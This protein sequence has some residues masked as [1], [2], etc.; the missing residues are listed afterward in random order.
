MTT[1]LLAGAAKTNITPPIGTHMGGFGARVDG[2]KG[3]HDT[4]WAKALVLRNDDTAVALVACD[5]LGLTADVIRP[6]R[7]AI[8]AQLGV[9]VEHVMV[10]CSHTH[11]GPDSLCLN[12]DVP[13]PDYFALVTKQIASA[14]ELAA[15]QLR[16]AR[17][18]WGRG[19]ADGISINR[20]TFE[21]GPLDTEVGVL[22]VEDEDQR[23]LALVVNFACHPVTLG[24]N[25]LLFCADYPGYAMNLLEQADPGCVALFT[26]GAFGNV[27]TGHSAG[28][29]VGDL[30]ERTFARA[31]ALGHMLA[32]EAIKV[33][34]AIQC[35]PDSTLAGQTR[36]LNLP[37]RPVPDADW[38]A[39]EAKV[40]D[41]LKVIQDAS[42]PQA[43]RV[44]AK[45]RAL[46]DYELLRLRESLPPALD[47]EASVLRIGN[48]V[49][50]GQPA[51]YFIEYQI[52]LKQAS[53][54][55][56]TFL[57]GLANDWVGY[58]PTLDA[59]DEGGYETKLCRWSKLVPECGDTIFDA[60]VE[61]VK[62]V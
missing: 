42:L 58:V 6:A 41:A 38:P 53:P 2:A 48:G 8:A 50:A 11:S 28:F 62:A 37:T 47:T 55:A 54:H 22:R 32:G 20:R 3:V 43:E 26:N 13:S 14:A 44:S 21:K 9:P 12:T 51:E 16:P 52:A 40:A 7:E 19:Q 59:F 46:Y 30:G 29:K 56:F 33:H 60:L 49:L 24:G 17:V 25:N 34:N 10:T 1:P 39:L 27:N 61:L 31:R 36:A 45:S 4:L 23:P 57:A 35:A 5:L 15:G 18:G